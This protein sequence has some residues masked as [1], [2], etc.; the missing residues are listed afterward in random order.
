M[1][2]DTLPDDVLVPI[3]KKCHYISAVHFFS[4][5]KHMRR[6]W[7]PELEKWFREVAAIRI[8]AHMRSSLA[9]TMILRT[10]YR[11]WARNF[12]KYTPP[13]DDTKH[14]LPDDHPDYEPFD[15]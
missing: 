1:T 8:R 4:A 9:F 6:L 10:K 7:T 11:K 2:I 14:L 3:G 13:A 5:S 15:G 12:G